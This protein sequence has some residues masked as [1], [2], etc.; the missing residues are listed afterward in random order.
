MESAWTVAPSKHPTSCM[1]TEYTMKVSVGADT[2][3]L[4]V[5]L[6]LVEGPDKAY[7]AILGAVRNGFTFHSAKF[8]L[9]YRDEDGDLC[10]LAPATLEDCFSLFRGGPMRLVVE[11]TEPHRSSAG[12]SN[13][14]IASLPGSPRCASMEEY[15][16]PWDI[17]EPLP[18]ATCDS[19]V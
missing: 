18:K 16:D 7:A 5:R 15:D 8:D 3:R 10:T 12:V 2:R 9:K 17:V 11:W 19:K 14:S 6:S 13:F 1:D 4:R